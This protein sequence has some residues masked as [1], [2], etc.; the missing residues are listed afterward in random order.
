MEGLAV[1]ASGIAVGSLAIQI[2]Q[3]V[4]KLLDLLESMKS[5][6]E[7]IQVIS[8]D[9]RELSSV[10]DQMRF[11]EETHILG[12]TCAEK[13]KKLM[14]IVEEL[15]PGFQSGSNAHRRKTAFKTALR[16][17]LLKKLSQSIEE[18]KTTLILQL[19]ISR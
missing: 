18:T 9:L 4:S 11:E 16:V 15:E 19:S 12:T 3:S 2:T 14:T 6:P 7:D 5:A 1:A 13:I 10:L 17:Q 8:R